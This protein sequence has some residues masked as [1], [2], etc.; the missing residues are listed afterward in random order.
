MGK[1]LRKTRQREAISR[2]FET[3]Q[4]PLHA[5]EILHLAQQDVPEL[6][7]ATVYRTLKMMVSERVLTEVNLR[8]G[9]TR[10]EPTVRQHTTFLYCDC[11]DKAFPL[12][13]NGIDESMEKHL[14]AIPNGFEFSHCEVTFVGVCPECT[15]TAEVQRA[16]GQ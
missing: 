3:A 6:G 13:A 2:A 14:N 15:P 7:L 8:S 1:H 11:C 12:E 10:Y 5:H 9:A 4:R 16:S